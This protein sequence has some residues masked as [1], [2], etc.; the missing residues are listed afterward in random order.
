MEHWYCIYTKAKKEDQVCRRLMDKSDIEVFN[1][2]L[3]RTQKRGRRSTDVVEALFPCYLFSRFNPDKYCHMIKYTSGVKRIVGDGAG[4]PFRVDDS[5][6]ALIKS[7]AKD[8]FVHCAE[9]ANFTAGSKVVVKEGPL[10]GLAGIFLEEITSQ[11]R[12]IILLNAIVY[13]A[14][15]ELPKTLVD[16]A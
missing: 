10:K 7:R 5:I 16:S 12:V 2:K 15:V 14:R 9:R 1:P 13:Q 11:E 4:N 3:M 8:G 6:I